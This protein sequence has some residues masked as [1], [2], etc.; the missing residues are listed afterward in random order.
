MSFG[1]IIFRVRVAQCVPRR[2]TAEAPRFWKKSVARYL[3]QQSVSSRAGWVG[4][5]PPVQAGPDSLL[6]GDPRALSISV[7]TVFP[8]QC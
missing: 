8:S 1:G 5:G 7:Q 6:G 3:G 4:L 2:H